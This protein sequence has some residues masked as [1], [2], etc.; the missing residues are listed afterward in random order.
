MFVSAFHSTMD[1]H[2]A[3]NYLNAI[4][5]KPPVNL[6]TKHC[7]LPVV[8]HHSRKGKSGTTSHL[9]YLVLKI[10]WHL[11]K[12]KSM[13]LKENKDNLGARQPHILPSQ[14][15]FPFTNWERRKPIKWVPLLQPPEKAKWLT[16]SQAFP[17]ALSS[18]GE[19][20]IIQSTS[21]ETHQPISPNLGGQKTGQRKQCFSCPARKSQWG[22]QTTTTC[23][24]FVPVYQLLEGGKE[25]A[26]G[27]A[28]GVH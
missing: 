2:T 9:H 3:C 22:E 12:M 14:T 19:K 16:I 11:R 1:P 24:T 28:M 8:G 13:I 4:V 15:T 7:I 21:T 10:P 17:P 20:F 18:M 6:E 25:A 5:T 23:C 26:A 27:S